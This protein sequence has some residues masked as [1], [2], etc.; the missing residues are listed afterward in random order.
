M[1]GGVRRGKCVCVPS[2]AV[3][4]VNK[5]VFHNRAPKYRKQKKKTAIEGEVDRL[6]AITGTVPLPS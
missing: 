2:E 3:I 1:G 5:S 6:M 4:F